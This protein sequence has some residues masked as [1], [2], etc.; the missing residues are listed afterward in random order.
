MKKMN[1]THSLGTLL[2]LVTLLASCSD[3]ETITKGFP[4]DPE[5]SESEDATISGLKG[6]AAQLES[7]PGKVLLTAFP[8]LRVVAEFKVNYTKDSVPY[9]G[10]NEYHYSYHDHE[11]NSG[12]DWH[13]HFMPGFD[14][15][16]GFNMINMW[17]TDTSGNQQRRVFSKP[18]LIKNIYLP[19]LLSDTL[20]FQAVK[21]NYYFVSAYSRDTNKDGYIDL[22]DLRN[23]YLIS[24]D[25]TQ[26]KA[27][28]PDDYGVI[29][30]RYD[31]ILD[32]MYVYTHRDSNGDGQRNAKELISIYWIDLKNPENGNWLIQ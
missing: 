11:E 20:N 25:G 18:T 14:L 23:L 3:S 28:L 26:I 12:N 29:G 5:S 27:L 13:H 19:S 24:L 22:K 21:R 1:P 30:S 15:V 4:I 17:V 31:R 2:L 8:N 32:R 9:I 10:S 16:Y 6:D 7:R